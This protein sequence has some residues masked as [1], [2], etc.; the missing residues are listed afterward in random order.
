MSMAL[1]AV[2]RAAHNAQEFGEPYA[3]VVQEDFIVATPLKRARQK[4]LEI[5]EVCHP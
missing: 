3:V 4:G 2:K 1:D 5:L